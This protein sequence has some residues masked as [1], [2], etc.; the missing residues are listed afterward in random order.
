MPLFFCPMSDGQANPGGRHIPGHWFFSIKR[1][2]GFRRGNLFAFY[3]T[4]CEKPSLISTMKA[5]TP[6]FRLVPLS[7]GT[8]R[9][10]VLKGRFTREDARRLPG[11]YFSLD[12]RAWLIGR[13]EKPAAHPSSEEDSKSHIPPGRT[14][15]LEIELDR[16]TGGVRIRFHRNPGWNAILSGEE[17]ARWDSDRKEWKMTGGKEAIK[18]I[19]RLFIEEPCEM[20]LRISGNRP[21]GN[22]KWQG[23]NGPDH[24]PRSF[25]RNMKERGYSQRSVMIYRSHINRFLH[26][27]GAENARQISITRLCDYI[28]DQVADHEYSPATHNQLINALQLFYALEYNRHINGRLLPRPQ[29]SHHAP[30]TLSPG[31]VMR[32]LEATPGLKNRTLFTL[33]YGT[34]MRVSEAAGL[35]LSDL[36][37]ERESVSVRDAEGRIVRKVMLS[38]GVLEQIR[39]YREKERP[40]D[41]L[42]PG[43]NGNHYSVR[44]IQMAFKQ[45]LRNAGIDR[46]VPVQVLR[47][48]FAA[49]LLDR[50][51]GL[52]K[53]Q[54]LLGHR[55]RRT[56]EV[57]ARQD[58][59]FPDRTRLLPDVLRR[60]D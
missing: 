56:T 4:I 38:P 12:Q 54:G 17:R 35:L 27:I 59:E 39:V 16:H 43:R 29:L 6:D 15:N 3:G 5:E 20:K 19:V 42:F 40:D 55:S 1:K 50:G 41:Y 52:K 23:V 8:F 18:R 10:D 31:E 21:N 33:I 34:G 25:L 9:I 13:Q 45:S 22:G 48:S 2:N 58:E 47:H 60:V 44:S 7:S 49:H 51:A 32:I 30:K 24:C 26:V 57:Y 46:D 53:V 28:I 36:D 14:R 11:C 37:E